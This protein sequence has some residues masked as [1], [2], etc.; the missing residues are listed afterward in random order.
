[1]ITMVRWAKRGNRIGQVTESYSRVGT[2]TW[3]FQLYEVHPEGTLY[4]VYSSEYDTA[5]GAIG[6]W[7][8]Y[9]D[10]GDY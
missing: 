2:Y 7:E 9:R 3:F 10:T 6:H 1:M 8:R 5:D 4:L